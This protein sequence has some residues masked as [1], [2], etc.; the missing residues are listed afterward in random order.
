MSPHNPARSAAGAFRRAAAVVGAI[1]AS[2]VVAAT[3]VAGSGPAA[4]AS[5]QRRAGLPSCWTLDS[6][7]DRFGVAIRGAR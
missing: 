4:A 3:V 2:T 6:A 5:A 7:V 1:V